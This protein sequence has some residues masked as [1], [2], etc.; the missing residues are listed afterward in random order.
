MK[1][2]RRFFGS[3]RLEKQLDAELEFHLEQQIRDYVAAGLDAEEA[4]RRARAEFGAIE[5]VKEECREARGWNALGLA[6]R[7][8]AAS[9]DA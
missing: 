6:G 8:A 4:R 3:S 9:D 7:E 5:Q 2:W 1:W